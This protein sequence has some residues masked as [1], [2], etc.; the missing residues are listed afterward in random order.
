[1][2]DSFSSLSTMLSSLQQRLQDID[3]LQRTIMK[4]Y[5]STTTW[6]QM[7]L[8]TILIF[9]ITSI[10]GVFFFSFDWLFVVVYC[11]RSFVVLS[12][13]I[14]WYSFRIEMVI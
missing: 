3:S 11:K 13:S 6:I 14:T 4:V 12:D 2:M 5:G 7:I 8:I 9:I 10:P 1:M